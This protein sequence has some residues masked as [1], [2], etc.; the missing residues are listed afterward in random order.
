MFV[1]VTIFSITKSSLKKFFLILNKLCLNKKLKI[2]YVSDNYNKTNLKTSLT[3]LKSPHV[4][5]TA[6]EHYKHVVFKKRIG[7]Y[8]TSQLKLLVILKKL[9][10]KILPDLALK[11]ELTAYKAPSSKKLKMII[12][13]DKIMQ[14]NCSKQ[15]GKYFLIDNYLRIFDIYGETT[16]KM[17]N[18][19]NSSA[20]RAKD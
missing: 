4:N 16:F 12:N 11:I 8:T 7:L 20:G 18:C 2:K 19:L 3:V 14:I 10:L 6:Q 15:G 9:E 17:F 13:P 5:K 1:S